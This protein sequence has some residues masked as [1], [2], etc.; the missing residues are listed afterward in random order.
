M[1]SYFWGVEG[2][3]KMS[4]KSNII[5]MDVPLLLLS[6]SSTSNFQ[7]NSKRRSKIAFHNKYG[8][9]QRN[10]RDHDSR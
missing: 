4:K 6:F 2:G 3:L 1:M 7:Y 10:L 5:D 8:K 9:I